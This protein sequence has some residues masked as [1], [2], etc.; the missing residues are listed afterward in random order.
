ML[1]T[2]CRKI[3]TSKGII[4]PRQILDDAHIDY[5][6]ELDIEYLE[7]TQTIILKKTIKRPLRMGWK[8]A[9]IEFNA[10]SVN[11]ML[12]PDIFEDEDLC[13]ETI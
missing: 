5:N 4:L 10:K 3:G 1:H 11:E 12:I 9:F 7:S 8:E 13:N 6:D 2:K